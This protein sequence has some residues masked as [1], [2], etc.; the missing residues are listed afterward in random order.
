[1]SVYSRPQI[2]G[3]VELSHPDIDGRGRELPFRILCIGDFAGGRRPAPM[4]DRRPVP[5]SAIG[6]DAAIAQIRP[7]L[8]GRIEDRLGGRG[9]LDLELRFE[10]LSDFDPQVILDRWQV[11]A[12]VAAERRCMS[13]ARL[14]GSLDLAADV[15]ISDLDRLIAAQLSVLEAWTPLRRLESVWRSAAGLLA[16][17]GGLTG[18]E[19][20]L[21]AATRSEIEEDL[22]DA[23]DQSGSGLFRQIHGE[24]GQFGGQPWSAV[25]VDW[26][27]GMLRRDVALLRRLA[28]LGSLAHA[29]VIVP[30]APDLAGV[31]NWGGLPVDADVADV[32]AGPALAAWRAFR[33]QPEARHAVLAM[34]RVL[35]REGVSGTAGGR[36]WG[37]A[38]WPLAAR[39]AV[40]HAEQGWCCRAAG[41]VPGCGR[42]GRTVLEVALTERVVQ[43]L[44]E[45]GICALM[46][47]RGAGDAWLPGAPTAWSG[48]GMAGRVL[49][50]GLDG[51]LVMSRLAHHMK[52]MGRER[53]GSWADRSGLERTLAD[54]LGAHVVDMDDPDPD[55]LVR[56]PLRSAQVRVQDVDGRRG[57]YRVSVQVTPHSA[58]LGGVCTLAMV[59]WVE[60][61]R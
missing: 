33:Q 23:A 59:S 17:V 18:V 20:H 60:A 40:A 42:A 4:A 13:A 12:A 25:V 22:D 6:I 58:W 1:M 32:H 52:V 5:A 2:I 45:G 3:R 19:V 35:L 54:W 37:A 31:G 46:A 49:E 30:A 15:A 24:Y 10:A 14:H 11:L 50:R 39:L 8:S 41:P 53:I 28:A 51:V 16:A 38:A 34:P 43:R 21:L 9:E 26:E 57:W 61:Q 48:P 7:G 55:L 44:A 36:L 47:R 29:P 56:R 27:L